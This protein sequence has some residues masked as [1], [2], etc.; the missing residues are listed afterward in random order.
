[1]NI[2]R[3][4]GTTV[5]ASVMVAGWLAVFYLPCWIV[6]GGALYGNIHPDFWPARAGVEIIGTD[7]AISVT[8]TALYLWATRKAPNA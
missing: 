7:L 4:A 5:K 6:V 1:M 3:A 8:L 2:G